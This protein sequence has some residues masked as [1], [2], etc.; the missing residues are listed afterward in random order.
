MNHEYRNQYGVKDSADCYRIRDGVDYLCWM[1]GMMREITLA[2][3]KR[4][5]ATG[6]RCFREKDMIFVAEEDYSLADT[7]AKL[8][9]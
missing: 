7:E 1:D 6:A 2:E 8:G 5:K 9:A 3:M 4:L